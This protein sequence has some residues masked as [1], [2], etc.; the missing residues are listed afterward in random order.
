MT[1]ESSDV[2]PPTPR[3]LHRD[4]RELCLKLWLDTAQGKE[5]KA[6]RSLLFNDIE[7]L[8][9]YTQVIE[10]NHQIVASA[11]ITRRVITNG[12]F[13][14][15]VGVVDQVVCLSEY[16]GQGLEDACLAR[17]IEVMQADVM[18]IAVHPGT[19]VSIYA[20]SGFCTV[21]LPFLSS[22]TNPHIG[23]VR[24]LHPDN[25]FRSF[26]FEWN[27]RWRGA[28]MPEGAFNIGTPYGVV[29]VVAEPPF[30]RVLQEEKET[31]SLTQAGFFRL[32]WG[33]AIESDFGATKTQALLTALF[34]QNGS[35]W[36]F[37]N[38]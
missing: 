15:T 6:L 14:L 38:T 9:Y 17:A 32:L 36:Y 27:D 4:E 8:P 12:E 34:P 13:R 1:T 19:E 37:I 7:W 2:M 23:M 10:H 31:F 35:V 3:E 30:L 20:N 22:D 25:L 24:L 21:A 5:T 18:D 33:R 26:L 28:G 16:C 11:H 29:S